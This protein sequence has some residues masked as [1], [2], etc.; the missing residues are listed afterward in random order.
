MF[1]MTRQWFDVGRENFIHEE[2]RNYLAGIKALSQPHRHSASAGAEMI[3]P[4]KAQ[5]FIASDAAVGFIRIYLLFFKGSHGFGEGPR[6]G[7]F[8]LQ[9]KERPPRL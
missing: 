3:Y 8:F 1:E 6:L 5:P 4:A 7:T 2:K 9:K